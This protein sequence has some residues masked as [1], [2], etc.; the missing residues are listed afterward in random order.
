MRRSA[1]P[2]AGAA[3]AGLVLLAPVAA[4]AASTRITYR[5]VGEPAVADKLRICLGKALTAAS[6][7][8]FVAQTPQAKLLVLVGRDANDRINAKG[9]SVAI[10]HLSNAAS[11]FLAGKLL[12]EGPT[13]TKDASIRDM[14]VQMVKQDGFMDYLNIGHMDSASDVE[15]A[16]LCG[17]IASTFLMKTPANAGGASKPQ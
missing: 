16:S 13:Q 11:F 6:G 14:L 3:L 8:T 4:T 2:F 12:P 17:S 5:V 10:T 9:V 7:Y 15:I 1:L